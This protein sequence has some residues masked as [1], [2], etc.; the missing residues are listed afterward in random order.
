MKVVVVD[1]QAAERFHM[2]VL[3]DHLV[4][5][6]LVS[7]CA[8]VDEAARVI[9]AK[10]P[11]VVFLDIELGDKSGFDLLPLL[12]ADPEIVFVTLHEEYALRAFRVNAL[13]YLMKPVT[14]DQLAETLARLSGRAG[15][16]AAAASPQAVRED[17]VTLLREEK[18][19][20]ML[21]VKDILFIEASGDYT[22]VHAI[23]GRTH[24]VRRR[25]KEWMTM[26]PAAMFAEVDRTCILNTR[27][28]RAVHSLPGRHSEVTFDGIATPLKLGKA[29]TSAIRRIF[30]LH[31]T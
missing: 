24:F 25:M 2:K 19:H 23:D 26:L 16:G 5:V 31:D 27:R 28:I 10:R 4:G 21:P 13:D 8:D 29:A 20:V 22:A 6:E 1:D 15:S 18:G 17:D 14:S 3:L 12:E 30:K 11:D 7:S 9:N